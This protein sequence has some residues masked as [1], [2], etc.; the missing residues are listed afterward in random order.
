MVQASWKIPVTQVGRELRIEL[1]ATF[2]ESRLADAWARLRPADV[3]TLPDQRIDDERILAQ[4]KAGNLL[5][6]VRLGA[7]RR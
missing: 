4:R 1:R 5:E 3:P 6:S 7:V 2:R